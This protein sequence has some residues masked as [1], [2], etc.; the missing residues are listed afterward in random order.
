MIVSF[1]KIDPDDKIKYYRL[2]KNTETQQE[3]TKEHTSQRQVK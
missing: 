3:N 1:K 2:P